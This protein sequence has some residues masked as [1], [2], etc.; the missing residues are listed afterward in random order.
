MRDFF[1]DNWHIFILFFMLIIA[2]YCAVRYIDTQNEQRLA[3]INNTKENVVKY[4]NC[5]FID[6][7]YYCWED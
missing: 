6:S 5:E 7:Y 3:I 2:L 4:K 1:E